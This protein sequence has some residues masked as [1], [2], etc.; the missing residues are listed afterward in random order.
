MT[1]RGNERTEADKQ[2]AQEPVRRGPNWGL[3]LLALSLLI[4][5]AFVI[6]LVLGNRG[7]YKTNGDDTGVRPI[8]SVV[9]RV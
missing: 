3:I 8:P 5:I 2:F 1:N 6:S 9:V 7:D 4:V